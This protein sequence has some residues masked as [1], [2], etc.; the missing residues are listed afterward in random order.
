MA[1]SSFQEQS[2]RMALGGLMAALSVVILLLGGVVP[3][4]TFACPILAMVCLLPVLREYGPRL[5]LV[6]YAA[7]AVLA[8]LLAAD[9]E[10]ALFYVF[11]GYYPVAKPRLD[12][13]SS[14]LLRL[15]CKCGLFTGSTTAMYLLILYLFRLEA[16]AAEFAGYSAGFVALL[17]LLGN[18]TFLV[19]D[20]ALERLA[21]LYDRVLRKKLFR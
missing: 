16:V 9:K 5:A 1:R 20:R 18:L 10:L 4:A 2:R 17:L 6:L 19:L 13:L 12:Q 3:L 7:V 21:F 14:P 11:L 8:L 15:L